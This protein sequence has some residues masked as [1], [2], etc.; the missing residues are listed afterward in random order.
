VLQP[1][2]TPTAMMNRLVPGAQRRTNRFDLRVSDIIL[3]DGIVAGA[4]W[5]GGER[6]I[7]PPTGL[8]GVVTRER[9]GTPVPAALVSIQGTT[10]TARTND[11]GEFEMFTIPGKYTVV[12]IDTALGA[13]VA[14]RSRERS[15]EVAR[16]EMASVRLELTPL[17]RVMAGIC[18]DQP[19]PLGS[20]I[21]LGVV[22]SR[23]GPIPS[24]A[25]VR[26]SWLAEVTVNGAGV[27]TRDRTLHIAPDDRGRFVI[28]GVSTARPVKL[29]V[30][31]GAEVIADTTVTVPGR[32]LSHRVLWTYEAK[33][34]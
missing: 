27:Q 25:E 31:R 19:A 13:L 15:L 14:P 18:R 29:T 11:R 28:C 9:S 17:D 20:S 33:R 7:D 5:S 8:R 3:T 1:S 34:P 12:A 24:D 16:G 6:W 4:I 30:V 32:Q 23:G 26:A 21:I 2:K 10:D 22:S